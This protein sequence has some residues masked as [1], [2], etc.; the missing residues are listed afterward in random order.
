[1]PHLGTG[2]R[3]F[4]HFSIKQFSNFWIPFCIL[5]IIEDL[6]ELLFIWVMPIDLC[7]NQNGN[8]VFL[9]FINIKIFSV[10]IILHFYIF[11]IKY[12]CCC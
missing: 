6:K 5:K 7:N 2:D 9:M 4:H 10:N 11:T 1:M 3:R 8:G 12:V